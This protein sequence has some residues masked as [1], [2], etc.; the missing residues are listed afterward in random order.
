MPTFYYRFDGSQRSIHQIVYDEDEEIG[1]VLDF[2]KKIIA[3]HPQ[4]SSE[5]DKLICSN[6]DGTVNF[7]NEDL[8]DDCI[9]NTGGLPNA[10]F[11]IKFD[12]SKNRFPL[13]I[14]DSFTAH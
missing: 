13:L 2:K 14:F 9:A 6:N 3:A 7:N 10:P 5:F 11:L 4:L 8:L 12:I 1:N